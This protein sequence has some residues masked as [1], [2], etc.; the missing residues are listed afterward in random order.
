MQSIKRIHYDEYSFDI[1]ANVYEPAED[2]FLFAENLE[3][4]L[5]ANVLDVGTGCGLLAVLA[6]AK[7]GNV[8]ALD[9][10][11]FAV[12][13]AKHNS[14][15]NNVQDKISFFQADLFTAFGE[16]TLFDL[17]TF[18]AP[19]L[20]GPQH[21]EDSWI[22][23]SWAGGSDGRQVIDRFI[24]QAPSHLKRD[25]RIL[26]MQSTLADENKTI[27]KFW[28]YKLSASVIA[29]CT[30]PFFETLTLVQAKAEFAGSEKQIK[31]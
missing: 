21:E 31:E 11:P 20:P 14:R 19:Y 7:K 30:L 1:W 26:M 6:A 12:R 16:A 9:L 28:E 8:L 29:Q 27:R 18:N 22:G 4:P 10:N 2:S 17:I 25:G 5:G 13:C 15:L 23:R 24:S 3:V